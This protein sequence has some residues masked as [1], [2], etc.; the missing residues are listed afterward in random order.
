MM[1]DL[2]QLALWGVPQGL[3]LEPFGSQFCFAFFYVETLES[4]FFYQFQCFK[5]LSLF[6]AVKNMDDMKKSIYSQTKIK[7]SGYIFCH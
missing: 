6:T 3:L 5:N 1:S 2:H 4:F 7:D